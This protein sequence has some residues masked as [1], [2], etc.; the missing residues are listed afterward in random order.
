MFHIL[1][2]GRSSELGLLV[3][4][5]QFKVNQTNQML[6][7]HERGKSYYLKEENQLSRPTCDVEFVKRTRDK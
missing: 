3:K 4:P 6:V 1:F 7:P 2:G 5:M